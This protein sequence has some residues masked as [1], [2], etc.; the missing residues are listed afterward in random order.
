MPARGLRYLLVLA[1]LP[2]LLVLVQFAARAAHGDVSFALQDGLILWSGADLAL[3]GQIGA[4]FTPQLFGHLFAVRFGGDWHVWAYP[5]SY[6]L[7]VS[8][9]GILPPALAVLGF[10]AL[11]LALLFVVLRRC[12]FSRTITALVLVSPATL[13]N[14]ADHSNG[15]LFA[16]CLI[17]AVVAAPRHPLVGGVLAGMLSMKPQLALLLPL[18]WLGCGYWRPLIVALLTACV[19]D[20]LA[21]SVFGAGSWVLYVR[22]V[23]PYMH[24]V[25]VDLTAKPVDG[26]RAMIMSVYSFAQQMG[27]GGRLAAALQGGCSLGA[28]ALAFGLG[29]RAG[30]PDERRLGALLLLQILATPYMWFYDMIPAALA[31]VLLWRGAEARGFLPTERLA[32]AGIWATPGMAWLLAVAGWPSFMPVFVVVALACLCSAALRSQKA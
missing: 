24:G 4:V 16:A 26:P 3:T 12:G 2:P 25:L 13:S 11:T 32:L 17:G 6:L 1:A 29:R 28:A 21:A 30:W 18:Y 15:A 9:F 7:L 5:P 10:D 14:L 19:L 8:P 23:L 20:V 22:Q 31:T 27:G